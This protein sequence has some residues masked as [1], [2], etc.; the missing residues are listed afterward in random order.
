MP[1]HQHDV[2]RVRGGILNNGIGQSSG[3][4]ALDQRRLS[5]LPHDVSFD[6]GPGTAM[7]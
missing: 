7:G 6:V 5:E 2:R 4:D 3:G 1:L